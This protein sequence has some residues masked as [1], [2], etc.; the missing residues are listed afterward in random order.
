ML[1][2][3][4]FSVCVFV[5][6]SVQVCLFVGTTTTCSHMVCVCVCITNRACV[7]IFYVC[8]C[9]WRLPV[10][11]WCVLMVAF[12]YVHDARVPCVYVANIP[13][14]CIVEAKN[15]ARVFLLFFSLLIFLGKQPQI[16]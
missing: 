14:G 8:V 6:L 16:D 10:S 12:N 9:V 2:I 13:L 1:D 11:T 15:K 7:E 3:I 4:L 5:C